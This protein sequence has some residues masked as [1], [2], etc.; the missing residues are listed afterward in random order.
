M[1]RCWK[2]T[3]AARYDGAQLPDLVTRDNTGSSV[4]A[5]T[6][7]R[8][9]KSEAWLAKRGFV[10]HIH[11]EKLKGRPMLERAKLANSRR[12]K[13]RSLVEHHFARIKHVMGLNVCTIGID[14]ATTKIGM[15]NLAYKFQR[16][17]WL[18]R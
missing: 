18:N 10:S 14:R 7:Y 15:A 2:V 5:D 1:I 8:S 3:D 13:I 12:S 17:I 4:W 16:L 11:I 9:K 6:A